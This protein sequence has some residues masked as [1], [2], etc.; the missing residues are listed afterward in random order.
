MADGS[1]ATFDPTTMPEGP[2][3]WQPTPPAFADPL[4]PMGGTWKTWVLESGDQLRPG[5]PPEYDSPA[6]RGE[7]LAVQE[8][9]R[10]RTLAQKSDAVWWQSSA[11]QNFN[12]WTYELIARHE[13]DTPHAARVLAYQA[14]SMADA[15]IAVWDAKYT[16]WTSRSIKDDPDTVTAFP[17]P[18]Y[19]DFPSGYSAISEAMAQIVGLF[20]PDA[21]EQLDE[22]AWRA[23]RSRAWEGIHYPLANEVGMCMGRRAAR[24]A[25]IRAMEEGALPT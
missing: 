13:L 17:T 11:S 4:E 18:P 22:L 12:E 10:T 2:G 14:V 23:T 15:V 8:I 7:L 20:F 25:A 21:A 19:P 24:I 3:F 16:W 5:A 1:D 6:W 9:V